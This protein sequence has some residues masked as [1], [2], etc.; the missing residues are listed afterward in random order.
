M[1]FGEYRSK[2]EERRVGG[3]GAHVYSEA[4][5]GADCCRHVVRLTS[6]VPPVSHMMQYTFTSQQCTGGINPTST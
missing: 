3:S 2:L 6:K 4:R 5:A 1:I